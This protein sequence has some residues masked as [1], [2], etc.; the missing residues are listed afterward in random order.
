MYILPT[1]KYAQY[2]VDVDQG[3]LESIACMRA[4]MMTHDL[5]SWSYF[6]NDSQFKAWYW[7]L[8][9]QE[10]LDYKRALWHYVKLY[11]S[12]NIKFY[13]TVAQQNRTFYGQP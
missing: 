7:H 3:E 6:F 10:R 1:H 11:A 8:S 12:D 5:Q 9:K 13:Y 2:F 4:L